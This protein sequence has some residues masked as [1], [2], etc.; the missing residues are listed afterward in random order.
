MDGWVEKGGRGEGGREEEREGWMEREGKGRERGMEDGTT[1]SPT[2]YLESR[3]TKI[4]GT[5]YSGMNLLKKSLVM[6]R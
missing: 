1:K 4:S 3:P 6:R 5:L 2:R